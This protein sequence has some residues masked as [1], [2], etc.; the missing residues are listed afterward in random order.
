MM[1]HSVGVTDP[2]WRWGF[3]TMPVEN[4]A[5]FLRLAR[6]AGYR[7]VTLDEYR[8]TAEAGRLGKERLLALTFDDGY[9]DNWVY[10]APLLREY[11]FTGT[12]FV[13]TDFIDPGPDPRPQ[14]DGRSGDRPSASGYL[15]LGEL[16]R[17]D[18]D[19]V[20]DVQSHAAT[21][22]WY[23][24][25]PR[26]TD[27]RSPGDGYCWMDWN[28]DPG[29][30]WRHLTPPQRPETWGDPVYEHHKALS[31]PRYRPNEDL[32]SALREYAAARG[33]DFFERPGWR[34][35]LFALAAA[36]QR[37]LP[38]GVM[39]SREEYLA[40]AGA[41]LAD[42]A[43]VLGAALNKNIRWLC[44]PGGGYSPELFALAGRLYA[45]TTVASGD[46]GA[47]APDASGC[48]RLRRFGPLTAGREPRI[49]YL[50]PFVNLLYLEEQRAR[51]PLTRLIRGGLT[52]FARWRTP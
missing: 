35:E 47:D 8:G 42:S 9:L 27:F 19:G 7:G 21:H 36:L 12:V 41:E 22:T 37:D 46:R 25:G 30:K 3:L 20:L 26:I 17:L 14:W 18:A 15:N 4:F 23:P 38:P 44:W 29:G 33:R 24:R 32:G 49:R 48:F 10:A 13:S 50:H 51:N 1:L 45:G 39:E 34:D 43:S 11:G 40:R 28:D 5:A 31:G 6:R 16:R 52:R 2:A